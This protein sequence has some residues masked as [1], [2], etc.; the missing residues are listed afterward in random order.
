M[1]RSTP[2]LIAVILTVALG[3]SLL[4]CTISPTITGNELSPEKSE[5]LHDVV[6][7]IIPV[8]AMYMGVRRKSLT[9]EE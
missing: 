6:T 5:M 3:L 9:V 7:Q 4:A 2:D 1:K 8:I